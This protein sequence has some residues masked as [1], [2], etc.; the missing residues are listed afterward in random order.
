[1][2]ADL[3]GT[4]VIDEADD[5]LADEVEALGVRCI[6]TPTVMTSVD[7]AERLSATVLDVASGLTP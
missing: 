7:D 5:A 3:A 6:V 2:Y 1:M 4:L